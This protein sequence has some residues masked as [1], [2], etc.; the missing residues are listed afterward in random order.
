[1]ELEDWNEEFVRLR[2]RQCCG[3]CHTVMWQM[4]H[5]NEAFATRLRG[6]RHATMRH[7]PHGYVANATL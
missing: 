6:I 2:V 4:P 5:D 3:K 1:M 7:S